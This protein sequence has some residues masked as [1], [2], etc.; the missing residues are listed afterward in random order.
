VAPGSSAAAA[1]QRLLEPL[2]VDVELR[3][4]L[5]AVDVVHD[6]L[7]ELAEHGRAGDERE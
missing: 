6:A 2:R 1:A 3:F 5:A 7:R 4:E